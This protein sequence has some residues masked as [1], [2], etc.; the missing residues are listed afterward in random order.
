MDSLREFQARLFEI[1]SRGASPNDS[2]DT[3]QVLDKLAA[4]AITAQLLRKSGA[5]IEVNHQYFRQHACKDVRRRASHLISSWKN[6]PGISRSSD[7]GRGMKRGQKKAASAF[8]QDNDHLRKVKDAIHAFR[9]ASTPE[10][11]PTGA[12]SSATP[13]GAALKR[14]FL[15]NSERAERVAKLMRTS[16]PSSKVSLTIVPRDVT[17]RKGEP[18][19]EVTRSVERSACLWQLVRSWA[20]AV[21]KVPVRS[22]PG[23][24]KGEATELTDA[25][26]QVKGKDKTLPFSRELSEVMNLLSLRSGHPQII[27]IWP[28]KSL[29]KGWGEPEKKK[30]RGSNCKVCGDRLVFRRR[31]DREKAMVFCGSCAQDK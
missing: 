7:T 11:R 23:G 30:E 12:S 20:T 18:V 8:S 25:G 10:R 22:L 3:I 4:E 21:L 2:V 27:V 9:I 16:Q 13:T 17:D 1:R 28:L 15:E 24:I 14:P 5:G 26:V 19:P 29:P 31:A 6:L